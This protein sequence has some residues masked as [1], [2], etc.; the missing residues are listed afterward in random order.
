MS[1][2]KRGESDPTMPNDDKIERHSVT[3]SG[4]STKEV[5][6]DYNYDSEPLVAISTDQNH[7]VKVNSKGTSKATLENMSDYERNRGT[8]TM[9]SGSSSVTV[10]HG[11]STTPST[12]DILINP[13][14]DPST[15]TTASYWYVDKSTIGSSNF[16][17]KTNSNVSSD[18]TF[19]WQCSIKDQSSDEATV[20]VIAIGK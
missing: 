11:M 2:V 18:V 1:K 9:T 6:W 8:A 10:S 3:V 19:T 16:D 5:S 14:E 7:N 13:M 15:D 20:E 12:E 17:I 4:G